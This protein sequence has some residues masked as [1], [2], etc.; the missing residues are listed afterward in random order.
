MKRYIKSQLNIITLNDTEYTVDSFNNNLKE[1]L[2]LIQQNDKGFWNHIVNET[3]TIADRL[4]SLWNKLW[5]AEQD[6]L[7]QADLEYYD[8]FLTD[9]AAFNDILEQGIKDYTSVA[10]EVKQAVNFFNDESLAYAIDIGDASDT[11]L[12]TTLKNIDT[13]ADIYKAIGGT[14]N[15]LENYQKELL[16]DFEQVKDVP[17]YTVAELAEDSDDEQV[18]EEV[19]A[20]RSANKTNSEILNKIIAMMEQLA[21]TPLYA[22][23]K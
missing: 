8:K 11:E 3:K 2:D 21:D 5:G 10:D 6:T 13:L 23:K 9:C 7:T 1:N 4:D 19:K 22:E 17:R 15:M 14:P 20:N 12:E 16:A 18:S